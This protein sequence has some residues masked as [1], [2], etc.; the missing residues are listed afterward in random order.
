MVVPMT[1]EGQFKNNG[2]YDPVRYRDWG[3]P[4][5]ARN[6]CENKSSL[7]SNA[8]VNAQIENDEFDEEFDEDFDN[9]P[10]RHLRPRYLCFLK[11]GCLKK[12][13][14]PEMPGYEVRKVTDW[15]KEHG[16]KANMEYILVSYTRKQHRQGHADL[17]RTAQKAARAVSVSAFWIDFECMSERNLKE[18]IW[19]ICDV[20]RGAR[21][22][23]I[24]LGPPTDETP[25]EGRLLKEW[26]K[27]LWTLPELLLSPSQHDIEIYGHGRTSTKPRK[28]AK[29]NFAAQAWDDAKVVRQLVDHY[30]GSLIL[31]PLELVSI[32]LQCL[33][34]RQTDKYHHGDES[35]ALMGLL[36]RR[37]TVN[38]NDSSF[39][40]FA[41]LSLA[42]DSN[43]LLE[44]LIC[45][46]PPSRDLSW[47]QMKDAWGANLWDIDPICQVAGI[48][49]DQT[50]LLD[51]AFGATIRWKS[52]APVAFIKRKTWIRTLGK[53]CVRGTPTYFLAGI[54]LL[55]TSRPFPGVANPM[56]VIGAIFLTF[57]L[58]L[59]L[60][61]PYLLLT[62]YKGK[63]WG[64]QAWFFGIE[65]EVDLAKIEEY[66]FGI[67]LDR[68]KWSTNGSTLSR[69]RLRG[70]ECVALT[71]TPTASHSGSTG[72]NTNPEA[73]PTAEY[74]GPNPRNPR[75][76]TENW[77]RPDH[78]PTDRERVFT[79]VDTYTMT[80]TMF[81]AV[82]P[83]TAVL[84]CGREGGMQR[85]VLCSY[86]WQTQTFCR[87]TV[88]RMKTIVL[89]KMFRVDRFRF[90]LGRN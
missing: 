27:R 32:A 10:A 89:E 44:R 77:R 16:E 82:R 18:D 4:K 84:I 58:V 42:N 8:Q 7:E 23:I 48:V 11:A 69:H 39:E 57:S 59:I 80:A 65:G 20:V 54:L 56:I 75:S 41:R 70:E 13:A 36:R 88:L 5:A 76:N 33:L 31:T 1:L 25:D 67:R 47:D 53:I 45:M 64:T 21:S 50:V 83:P 74:P 78:T 87:E 81:Y 24:A 49:D 34:R 43:L 52:L 85:A 66:L 90:A 68:L 61:S 30:E 28:L 26:G 38:E 22:L 71:P 29:R 40:A 51:G 12:G 60:A 14:R 9:L 6:L 72:H 86:D 79:L 35:Y 55:A 62:I 15:L 19:R 17:L 63:F 3:Y 2:F 73:E 46:L 37:P